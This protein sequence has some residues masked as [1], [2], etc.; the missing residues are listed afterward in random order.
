MD[1]STTFPMSLRLG[2][3]VIL[4]H[5]IMEFMATFIAFRYYLFLKKRQNDS[6][7]GFN[8]L[9]ALVGATLGAVI[10]SHLL[11]ACENIPEW[12]DSSNRLLYFWLNKTMAGGLIGGLIGVELAKKIVGEKQST[13][14]LFTFPLIMG[15]II[16]R[17]G[18][19]SVGIYEE[20][21]GLESG[22]PWAMNLGDGLLRHPVALYEILFLIVLWIGLKLIQRTY[23]LESGAIFKLFML[24][25]VLF[26][27]LLDFIKPGWRYFGGLGSIQLASLCVVIYY[28]FT[29]VTSNSRKLKLTKL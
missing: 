24:S 16:G 14:D 1:I 9:V 27:F 29:F 26:R 4:I 15:I 13:G 3:H 10:G 23:V 2:D 12:I 21:Y 28:I 8:R 19:F 22:L 5:G 17:V 18:C 11:G 25:Y 6:V 20:T 7:V